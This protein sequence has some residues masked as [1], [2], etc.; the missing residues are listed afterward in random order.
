MGF[1]RHWLNCI[2]VRIM[3]GLAGVVAAGMGR[4]MWRGAE[5]EGAEWHPHL[6]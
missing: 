4:V 5:A 2:G 1:K 3:R 6:F